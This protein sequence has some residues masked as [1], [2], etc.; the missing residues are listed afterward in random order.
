MNVLSLF[1]G[2]GG[3]DLG[4][5]RAGMQVVGQVEL[6]PFCRR[7]LPAHWPEV[8]RHDEIRTTPRW[9]WADPTRPP[10]HVVAGGFPCQPVSQAGTKQAQADPRWLWPAMAR[11]VAAVRP[12]WVIAENV[13]GLLRHGFGDVLRDLAT[14]GFDAEWDCVSAAAVGAPHLRDRVF[15]VAR[16]REPQGRVPDP[17]GEHGRERRPRRPD[18]PTQDR[19]EQPAPRLANPG[20]PRPQ[21]TRLF[22]PIA[23]HPDW[24]AEPRMGRVANGVPAG[25]DRLR[26][27]GNAVVPQVAEHIGRLVMAAVP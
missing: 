15:L 23:D 22:R 19:A 7:V 12:E 6:D 16:V 9:W 25:V 13:P 17:D 3:L 26:S 14:L 20:S 4:L 5:E 24:P 18:R 11:T 27:L 2:I 8:P 10:V 21:G 1:A